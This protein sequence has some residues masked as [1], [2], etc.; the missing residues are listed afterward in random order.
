MP[1]PSW[2]GKLLPSDMNGLQKL[3]CCRVLPSS[4]KVFGIERFQ[5]V[6]EYKKNQKSWRLVYW[7]LREHTIEKI[8]DHLGIHA[9]TVSPRKLSE[10]IRLLTMWRIPNSPD[11]KKSHR[12]KSG[13]WGG[14]P[15]TVYYS[16]AGQEIV[17]EKWRITCS[18]VTRMA[19]S[20]VLKLLPP[21]EISV[22]VT[23][24][25]VPLNDVIACIY[26]LLSMLSFNKLWTQNNT[27]PCQTNPNHF[28]HAPCTNE[29]NDQLDV[30]HP[31]LL[32]F[33]EFQNSS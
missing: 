18:C 5:S 17:H 26:S 8:P 11:K 9:A 23:G 19:G 13:E 21:H 32:I 16:S 24:A 29:R 27:L 10:I 30:H 31:S 12:V 33:H 20:S 7:C 25:K 22:D 14:G 1:Y 2:V 28:C 3:F 6:P 15:S 4:W